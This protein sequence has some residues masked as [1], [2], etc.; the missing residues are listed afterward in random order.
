MITSDQSTATFVPWWQ[1]VLSITAGVITLLIVC[2][3]TLGGSASDPTAWISLFISIDVFP[4]LVWGAILPLILLSGL[5]GSARRG[6]SSLSSSA[7]YGESIQTSRWNRLLLFAGASLF[8]FGVAAGFGESV[9]RLPP[10]YHDEYSYLFQ[11]ETFLAGRITNPSPAE[12]KHFD[13]IHVL[14]TDGVIASRYF[15]AVGLWLAPFLL[16]GYPIAAAWFAQ[17][18]TTGF[19]ALAASRL[20]LLAGIVVA[21]LVGSSP[22]L[23]VFGNTLLSPTIAMMGLA[24]G[25][26]AFQETFDTG[27]RRFAVIAG[28]AIAWVF[29]ARPL[30][31][32]AIAG[33]W[34]MYALVQ[35]LLYRRLSHQCFWAMILGFLPGPLLMASYNAGVTGGLT[36]TPY[37]HYTAVYTPS[38]AFGFY[39]R[40][41]G[42]AARGPETIKAY[43]DWVDELTPAKAVDI[44][45][46]RWGNAVPWIA[47]FIPIA[48][49]ASLGFWQ[50][51]AVGD[52]LLL[53]WLSI[54]GITLVH[55][56]FFY[57]G[58]L[59]WSYLAEGAPFLLLIMGVGVARVVGG[60]WNAERKL[61]AVWWLG[62]VLIAVWIGFLSTLPSAFNANSELIFP[63]RQAAVRLAAEERFNIPCLII[64]DVE[65]KDDLHST[66]VYNDPS[67]TGPILRAWGGGDSKEL[68][69]AFPDRA[70][71]QYSGGKYRRIR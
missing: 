48:I 22:G 28:L 46:N 64:Y 18:L 35:S 34:G 1:Q 23:V 39:N 21:V 20:S 69:A 9:S 65:L 40:T 55:V 51:R 5:H 4:Y 31:A 10:A 41:R 60:C 38:H 13:Q 57:G 61:L 67:F 56:P 58:I 25:W 27:K 12:A 52:R 11:A 29:L 62:P 42:V 30:T 71:Y 14:N 8:G 49:L 59:G 44:S 36:V 47:G 7:R 68:L 50:V 19:M 43:D 24:V 70:F 63:R 17:A 2:G 32:V 45:L 54:A 53:P 6:N 26:W 15:P 33:P 37:G 66:Y 16:L 3:E